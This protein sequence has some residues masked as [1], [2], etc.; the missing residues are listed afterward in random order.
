[1]YLWPLFSDVQLHTV[2]S[3]FSLTVSNSSLA[4]DPFV[5]LLRPDFS[6]ISLD[7]FLQAVI[8]VAASEDS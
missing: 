1:M 2:V 7:V 5:H 3:L 4:S 6:S 8:Q